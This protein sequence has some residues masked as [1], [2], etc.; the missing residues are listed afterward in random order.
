MEELMRTLIKNG[1]VYQNDVRS[2][3]PLDI[4]VE[5]G[6]ISKIV[7]RGAID[8]VCECVIDAS[9]YRLASGFIDVH[10]HG[11]AGSDFLCADSDALKRMS[12]AYLSHGVTTVMPTLASAELSQMVNAAKVI[13]D[14]EVD[15]FGARFCGVHLEG[16]YLNLERRG[17][18][19]PELLSVLNADEL[20]AFEDLNLENL[21]I[22]AAFELDTDKSFLKKALQIG[23]TLSLGHTNATYGQAA[24]LEKNGVTA[25]TH[26]YNA[27]PPLHHRE[28]GAVAAALLGNAYAELICDGIHVSPEMIA[29]THDIKQDR[30]TLISDSM[31]A[32]DCPDGKYSIAGNA[33]TVVEGIARTLDGALAGSTLTLDR[34][35]GNFMK[36]CDISLEDAIIAVTEAPAKEIGIFDDCGSIDIGKRADIIFIDKDNFNISSVLCRGELLDI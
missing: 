33:V 3:L 29:L 7:E 36:F 9:N 6:R 8:T 4:L 11:I 30:L 18:H 34:A 22:S 19:A 17:A 13:N 25:Y 15:N 31:E 27:M 35:L 5:N 28:G 24:E 21:H 14:F 2:F 16:R 1:T 32:T 12:R 26:L 23:A 20:A 10:T